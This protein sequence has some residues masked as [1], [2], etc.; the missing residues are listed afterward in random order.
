[1]GKSTRA[2][3]TRQRRDDPD[4][5][6]QSLHFGIDRAVISEIRGCGRTQGCGGVDKLQGAHSIV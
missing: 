5:F 3:P 2:H 6:E 1:V 4:V